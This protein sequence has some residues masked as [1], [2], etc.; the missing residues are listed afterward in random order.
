[1]NKRT[2]LF[3][4]TVFIFTQVFANPTEF[5]RSNNF[6]LNWKFHLGEVPGFMTPNLDEQSWRT[7]EL[8]HDW[9]IEGAFGEANPAG[10]SG[11]FLKNGIGCYRKLFQLPESLKVKRISI[12]FDGVY[13]NSTVYIN[14]TYLANRP[15]GFSTFEY[16]LTPYLEYGQDQNLIAVKVD[17]SLEPSC[18]WY[19]GSGINRNVYLLVKPQQH[20]KANGTFFRTEDLTGNKATLQIDLNI[21]SHN[22]PE[23]QV[24]KFQSR[25]EDIERT[26]KTWEWGLIDLAGFE[27]PTYY[28]RQSYW[29]E[30]PMVHIAVNL[31][32]KV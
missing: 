24:V 16:D 27:K 19:T 9:A 3:F 32:E 6:N 31:K 12:R 11:G 7:L 22:Y 13:M 2:T 10:E 23:S 21:V 15:Y 8:P 25:P 18:R 5:G 30:T 14:G 20:F 29:S 26:V 4:L 17:H 1:M 28:I